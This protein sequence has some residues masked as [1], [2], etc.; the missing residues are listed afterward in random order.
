MDSDI[1]AERVVVTNSGFGYTAFP[2]EV[3]CFQANGCEGEDFVLVSELGVSV[4]DDVGM[5]VATFAKDD[6]F[7]D[8]AVGADMAVFADT[9]S[10]V[11]DGSLM[12][13]T[14]Y[15]CLL[16]HQDKSDISFADNVSID[17]AFTCSLAYLAFAAG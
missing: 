5:K 14:H 15:G 8:H 13:L 1:L 3:L 4:D 16:I 9:G 7:T 10:G 6:L 11:H 2:F 12:D 17:E